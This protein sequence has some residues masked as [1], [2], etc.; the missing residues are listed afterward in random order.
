M[1]GYTY[2]RNKTPDHKRR[3]ATW[4]LPQDMC[5]LWPHGQDLSSFLSGDRPWPHSS[6]RC[7]H[8]PSSPQWNGSDMFPTLSLS[9]RL[10]PEH[11]DHAIH[12]CQG[13]CQGRWQR[14]QAEEPG[15]HNDQDK[16]SLPSWNRGNSQ[17]VMDGE[18]N[19]RLPCISQVPV[20]RLSSSVCCKL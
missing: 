2:L 1:Q 6:S 10:Q 9:L 12:L 19:T 17:P 13:K 14:S 4:D 11:C 20:V 16:Q 8:M 5:K 3:K 18:I 7:D 15:S